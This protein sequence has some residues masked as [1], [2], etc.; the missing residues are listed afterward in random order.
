M[1][2]FKVGDKVR[3]LSTRQDVD[4]KDSLGN[5]RESVLTVS[6]V[7]PY[8]DIRL[9]EDNNGYDWHSEN[10]ELVEDYNVDDDLIKASKLLSKKVYYNLAGKV[11]SDIVTCVS[12]IDRENVELYEY[13][14]SVKEALKTYDKVVVLDCKDDRNIPFSAVVDNPSAIVKLND[15]YEAEVFPD[16]IVVGCQTFPID[17]LHDLTAAWNSL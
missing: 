6:F 8:G 14:L 7:G 2:T 11:F 3:R 17:V 1:K 10:F 5:M 12:L 16:K 9:V 4:W 15:S 13:S